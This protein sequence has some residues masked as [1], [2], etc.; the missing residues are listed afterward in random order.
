MGNCKDNIINK[1]KIIMGLMYWSEKVM[2]RG[3]N[4][5]I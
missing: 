2:V 3:K 1:L 5:A 4:S